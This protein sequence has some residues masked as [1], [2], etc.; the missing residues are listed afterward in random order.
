M[1]MAPLSLIFLSVPSWAAA[2]AASR[3]QAMAETMNRVMFMVG[4]SL[5]AGWGDSTESPRPCLRA[6]FRLYQA[7]RRTFFSED[8][9]QSAGRVCALC[10]RVYDA[11]E[12]FRDAAKA[13]PPA[14]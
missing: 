6:V 9:A 3:A 14:I 7:A 11:A 8:H 13:R 2:G 12:G 4:V 1:V 5:C 10:S